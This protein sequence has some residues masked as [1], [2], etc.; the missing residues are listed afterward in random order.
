MT[1]YG[2]TYR[3]RGYLKIDAEDENVA[4][5]KFEAQTVEEFLASCNF[6]MIELEKTKED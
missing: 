1:E 5:E 3:L 6:Q 4:M 2:I